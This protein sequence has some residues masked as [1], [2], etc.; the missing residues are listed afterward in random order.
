[1][2]APSTGARVLESRAA[3]LKKLTKIV[4]GSALLGDVVCIHEDRLDSWPKAPL[5]CVSQWLSR[6]GRG[7][8]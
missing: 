2:A 4:E 7:C 3:Q 8:E 5:M 6:E 1:M